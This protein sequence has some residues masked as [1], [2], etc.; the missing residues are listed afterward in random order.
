MTRPPSAEEL[1]QLAKVWFSQAGALSA[2]DQ[3]EIAAWKKEHRKWT[4]FTGGGDGLAGA[5]AYGGGEPG[6]CGGD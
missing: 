4:H 2:Q 5:G 3:A 6:D 1:E